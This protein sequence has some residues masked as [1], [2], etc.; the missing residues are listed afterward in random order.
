M[1]NGTNSRSYLRGL[2]IGQQW[3]VLKTSQG[4]EKGLVR[5]LQPVLR[6]QADYDYVTARGL[7]KYEITVTYRKLATKTSRYECYGQEL[8]H[9]VVKYWETTEILIIGVAPITQLR[10]YVIKIVTFNGGHLV[11]LFHT[12][13]ESHEL[14]RI[15]RYFDSWLNRTQFVMVLTDSQSP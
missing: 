15:D 7:I 1:K 12:G 8:C 14:T 3:P 11:P 9:R 5:T 4:T 10:T 13:P 6:Y 2:C